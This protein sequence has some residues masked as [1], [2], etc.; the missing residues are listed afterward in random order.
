MSAATRQLEVRRVYSARPGGAVPVTMQRRAPARF[1]V[2]GA[3]S[4][5]L[6]ASWLYLTWWPA[7][8]LI[9]ANVMAAA[10]NRLSASGSDPLGFGPWLG[11]APED[12]A[13]PAPPEGT[14][15]LVGAAEK[16]PPAEA[17]PT[18]HEITPQNE[19]AMK[20][21]LGDMWAWLAIATFVGGWLAMC[22]GAAAAG[23][24]ITN[25]TRRRQAVLLAIM[26]AMGTAWLGMSLW[27]N[28]PIL[29]ASASYAQTLERAAEIA[30]VVLAVLAAWLLA[31][32]LSPGWA[33][34]AA[35]VLAAALIGGGILTSVKLETGYP[36]AAP[37]LGAVA[38]MLIA[39]LIG[40]SAYRRT[41]WLHRAAIVLVLVAT[42]ATL[43]GVTVAESFG[44]VY[45]HELTAGTYAYLAAGQASYAFV[46][47]AA[48]ALRLR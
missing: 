35:I 28:D 39:A 33:R 2:L 34:A 4:L 12:L 14:A 8:R 44:G 5:L 41:A 42:G 10:I 15:P 48:L 32:A 45:T 19:R 17:G 40:A 26:A 31:A 1:S 20:W 29:G 7:D 37:R 27:K 18:S 25:P 6:A 3:M 47:G 43:A 21:L 23:A 11:S 46:L 13:N 9:G 38:G 24:P 22:G 16:T 30:V 36:A